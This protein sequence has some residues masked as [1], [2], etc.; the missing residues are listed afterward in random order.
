MHKIMDFVRR[1]MYKPPM[2]RIAAL[3]LVMI[4]S[5]AF[6]QVAQP[7]TPVQ[8]YLYGETGY[9]PPIAQPQPQVNPYNTAY[10]PVEEYEMN[11]GYQEEQLPAD[12]H[13]RSGLQGMNY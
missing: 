7:L 4:A 12:D 10:A 8:Q 1:S 2:K 11:N 13:I 9:A 6:A 3:L 5:P